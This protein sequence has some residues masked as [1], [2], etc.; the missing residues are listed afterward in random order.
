[1]DLNNPTVYNDALEAAHVH[2]LEMDVIK[3]LQEL[4][5]IQPAESVARANCLY[6][7]SQLLGRTNAPQAKNDLLV[8]KNIFVKHFPA[9]HYVFK[10]IQ[11]S[12]KCLKNARKR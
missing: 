6:Y 1:L 12:L 4:A 5:A 2:G 9:S 11:A 3:L 7:G 8:A 10:G